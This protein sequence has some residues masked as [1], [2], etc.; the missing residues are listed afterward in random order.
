MSVDVLLN[1][2]GDLH[3]ITRLGSGIAVVRQRIQIRLNTFLGEWLLDRR[4]GMPI[5]EWMQQKPPRVEQIGAF[6]RREIET[7]PGV[8]RVEGFSSSL[9]GRDLS[10]SGTIIYD[11]GEAD[12]INAAVGASPFE[13]SIP[14]I[15]TFIGSGSVTP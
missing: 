2:D 13:S 4:V 5:L 8:L 10:Y 7:T 12:T 15:V 6:I 1:S 14:L 11:G 9:T 3:P